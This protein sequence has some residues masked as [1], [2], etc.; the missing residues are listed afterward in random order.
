M[1]GFKSIVCYRT[2]LDVATDA[3]DKSDKHLA[4]MQLHKMYQENDGRIRL[5]QKAL[6]DAVVRVALEVAG[7]HKIPGV[8]SSNYDLWHPSY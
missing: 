6:N 1:V 5:A 7:K 2:G 8:P 4:L 3:E